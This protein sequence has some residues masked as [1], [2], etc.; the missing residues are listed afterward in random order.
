MK[1]STMSKLGLFLA[2]MLA[3]A[4]LS[5]PMHASATGSPSKPDP[6]PIST[7]SAQ[8][9]QHQTQAQQQAIDL[10][11]MNA[12][13]GASIRQGNSYALSGG[14]APLPPGLCPKGD[15]VSIAWGLLAWSTTR[16]E[17]ECLDKVIKLL[18]DTAPKPVE[19]R[20]VS[21]SEPPKVEPVVKACEPEQPKPKTAKAAPKKRPCER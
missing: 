19:V 1:T 12:P 2:V 9:A 14:A 16:T 5:L 11:L 21:I 18:T 8:Q 3:I 6:A 20:Y 17:F 4:L 7:S 10:S 13:A 15:S